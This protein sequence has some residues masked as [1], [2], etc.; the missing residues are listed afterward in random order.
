MAE[1]QGRFSRVQW[2]LGGAVAS[3]A[4]GVPAGIYQQH[5]VA[6]GDQAEA[7][8]AEWVE[9]RP[10]AEN[11][12]RLI[13][14]EVRV[15]EH[16]RRRRQQYRLGLGSSGQIDGEQDLFAVMSYFEVWGARACR[17]VVDPAKLSSYIGNAPERWLDAFRELKQRSDAH[18]PLDAARYEQLLHAITGAECLSNRGPDR[19]NPLDWQPVQLVFSRIIDD[20]DRESVYEVSIFNPND[21]RSPVPGLC[22]ECWDEQGFRIGHALVYPP[23]AAIQANGYIDIRGRIAWPDAGRP[24][25]IRFAD[26]LVDFYGADGLRNRFS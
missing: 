15:R 1:K 13:T 5:V 11:A 7:G 20:G 18:P 17:G 23:D 8:F 21:A 3:A 10:R 14:G 12:M 2:L 26:D 25:S 24:T 16:R 19:I 22:I 9:L 6:R 4:V